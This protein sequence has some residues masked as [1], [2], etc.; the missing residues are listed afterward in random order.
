[1][2]S[3][4]DDPHTIQY[5]QTAGMGMKLLQPEMRVWCLK[6]RSRVVAETETLLEHKHI[7]TG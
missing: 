7:S 4:G 1:V 6:M 2:L 3:F 5:Y